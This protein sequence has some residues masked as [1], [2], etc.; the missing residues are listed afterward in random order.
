[1]IVERVGKAEVLRTA[2][3]AG[4]MTVGSDYRIAGLWA[5]PIVAEEE[6]CMAEGE[7]RTVIGVRCTAEERHTAA[8]GN[9]HTDQMEGDHMAV[10][11]DHRTAQ[12]VDPIVVEAG[13]SRFRFDTGYTLLEVR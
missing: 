4:R 9:H 8:E 2:E 5:A 10:E 11:E 7:H 1:M 12:E 3:A 13:R 6:R